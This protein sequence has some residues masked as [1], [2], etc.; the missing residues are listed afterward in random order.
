MGQPISVRHRT[1]VVSA[2][3]DRDGETSE[4]LACSADFPEDRGDEDC[5]LPE[6]VSEALWTTT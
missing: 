4:A 1:G 5:P 3:M 2:V 6:P